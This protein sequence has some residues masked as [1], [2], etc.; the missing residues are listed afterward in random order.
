MIFAADKEVS[1][2]VCPSLPSQIERGGMDKQHSPRKNAPP[3]AV[4]R[5]PVLG[6]GCC[7]FRMIFSLVFAGYLAGLAA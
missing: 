2:L 4:G 6:C 3:Q 1:F 5:L 7:L